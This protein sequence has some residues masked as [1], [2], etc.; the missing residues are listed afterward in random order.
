MRKRVLVAS[1]ALGVLVVGGVHRTA[2]AV[3]FVNTTTNTTIFQ[4]D[5]FE[6]D[7]PGSPPSITGAGTWSTYYTDSVITGGSPGAAFGN[8]YVTT[9][10]DNTGVG[11]PRANFSSFQGTNGQTIRGEWYGWYPAGGDDNFVLG[12]SPYIAIGR[13]TGGSFYN[14]DGFAYVLVPGFT[15]TPQAW[16]KWTIEYTIGASNYSL[17]LNNGTPFAIPVNAAGG[18]GLMDFG[19]NGND[20]FF[21]DGVLSGP[22]QQFQWITDSS[23]NWAS[24]SNWIGPVPN[25]TDQIARFL[26]TI[27]GPRTVFTDTP[28]TVG[29]A[30]FTNANS[31]QITGQ[32]TLT[33][34]VSNDSAPLSALVDV[35]QGTHKI[36]LPLTVASNTNFQVAAGATLKISDPLTINAGKSVTQSGA[37]TVVYESTVTLLAGASMA[38]AS[39]NH[40]AA[41]TVGDNATVTVAAHGSRVLEADSLSISSTGGKVDL[42]DNKMI[43]RNQGPGTFTAGAYTGPSG[44]VDRGRGNAGNALWNGSGVVTSDTRAINNGDLVSIGVAKVGEARNI[45]DTATTTFAGQIVRGSDTVAM[46]TWGGDANLD[47]KINIDDYGQIDSNVAK[48][49][50]VFGWNKGDFNYDGK[51]N[52]D[53]YGIIDGN[54]GRQTGT[55]PTSGALDAVSAVPEP[56]AISSL[57]L[58]ASAALLGRRRRQRQ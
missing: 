8:N 37:G 35:Q 40:V 39:S 4:S 13:I 5:G 9:T 32:G 25:G 19:H 57:A 31:Y 30:I 3:V 55:F 23:G 50:T 47:G 1:S 16:E 53:D 43:F 42:K 29:Q 7:T 6:N 26:G 46:V 34:Q 36:N 49:G 21:L 18:A 48:S 20:T 41:L 33:L 22:P 11:G 44:L 14:Y 28:V 2:R 51:I 24:T 52:I 38:L 10:R 15:Y 58:G 56:A 54:I 27:T 17:S 45:A 12:G